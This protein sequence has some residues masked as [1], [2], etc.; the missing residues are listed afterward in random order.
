MIEDT[1]SPITALGEVENKID[2]DE[3]HRK[4]V[5]DVRKKVDR[6]P[7]AISIGLDDREYGQDRIR[8]PLR[9]GTFGNISL[10]KG[11]EKARKSFL[12]SLLLSC[13]IGGNA[14]NYSDKIVGHDLSD[15]YI[16]DIDTEQGD[17]DVW[18][19]ATRI[20]K[21]VGSYPENY[22]PIALRGKNPVQIMAYL[23]WLFMESEYRNKLGIVSIDGFV[24]CMNDFNSQTESK[25]FITKLMDWS[26]ISMS[27]IT[28]ILHV[29]PGS[30]KARGH[31]G[32][33]IQQK[34]ETVV[35]IKDGGDHS[36]VIC[37]VGRGKKFKDFAIKIDDDWLPYEYEG[38]LPMD[39]A[40][41]L[42]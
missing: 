3:M 20:P 38:Y 9:F 28:G 10:I 18:L 4:A 11:E 39:A 35:M 14:N 17:Y 40:L 27:H 15:K 19:A 12:K 7:L 24:D 37:K 2:F 22:L 8:F 36:E 1:F 32:T 31:A 42:K 33:I 26:K 16:V 5:I 23:E 34:C 21:M 6:P 29:N 25:E 30:E 41:N 13:A